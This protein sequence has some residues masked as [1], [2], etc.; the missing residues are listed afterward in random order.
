VY[1]FGGGPHCCTTDVRRDGAL[2]SY[3]P[4]LDR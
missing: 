3:F 2:A 4:T 1:A